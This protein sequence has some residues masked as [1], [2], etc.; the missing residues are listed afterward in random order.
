MIL[1]SRYP[2]PSGKCPTGRS[3]MVETCFLEERVAMSSMLLH[4]KR[5]P[6][7]RNAPCSVLPNSFVSVSFFK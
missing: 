7:E 1:C 5:N 4:Q 3:G 2:S 6:N